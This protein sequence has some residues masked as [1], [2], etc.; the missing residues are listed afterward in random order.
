MSVIDTMLAEKVEALAVENEL[1]HK[2]LTFVT[3]MSNELLHHLDAIGAEQRGAT[4]QFMHS[5]HG[6]K[7]NWEH[8]AG[9]P[10]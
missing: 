10:T 1:L 3:A 6:S 8:L 9:W 5:R 4:N 2:R 7:I